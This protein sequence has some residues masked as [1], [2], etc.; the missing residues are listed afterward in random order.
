M[1][2]I[3]RHGQIV[4]RMTIMRSESRI[5]VSDPTKVTKFV[6]VD[7]VGPDAASAGIKVGQLLI[8]TSLKN[9]VLDAGRVFIPLVEEKD[10]ALF[11]SEVKREQLLVQTPNGKDFVS[12][13][14]EDAAKAI[15]VSFDIGTPEELKI[16]AA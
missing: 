12:F 10:V 14:S 15:G 9:I 7:A 1:K 11:L 4:G 13:E 6:L 3:P 2:F 8:V 5:I 16:E